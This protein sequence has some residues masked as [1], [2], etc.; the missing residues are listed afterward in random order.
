MKRHIGLL[1]LAALSVVS[2]NKEGEI[3]YREGEQKTEEAT[4]TRALQNASDPFAIDAMQQA[5]DLV[6]A[7]D[8]SVPRITLQPTGYYV[9]F[10]PQDSVQ[11]ATLDG[12]GIELFSHPLDNG[13]YPE[14]E[15]EE[16]TEDTPI[17]YEPLYAVVPAGFV[18]PEE[19]DYELIHGVFIQNKRGP[20]SDEGQL[21]AGVYASVLDASLRLTGNVSSARSTVQPFQPSARLRF[22]ITD[23]S[24]YGINNDTLPLVGAKVLAF[25]YT[26]VSWGVTDDN[27][28]TGPI[29]TTNTPVRYEVHWGDDRWNVYIANKNKKRISILDGTHTG[30]VDVVFADGTWE[31][32]MSG[33][34]TALYSYFYRDY[35][36]TRYLIKGDYT[37]DI[38]TMTKGGRSSAAPVR[39]LREIYFYGKYKG[40]SRYHTPEKAMNTMFHELGHISHHKLEPLKFIVRALRKDG[41][42][43]A[44]GVEYAYMKSFF[45]EYTDP[46]NRGEKNKYTRVVECLLK[47][48][49]SM[50]DIQHGFHESGGWDSW[51]VEMRRIV[52]GRTDMT[53]DEKERLCEI[54]NIIFSHPN[55]AALDLRDIVEAEYESVGLNQLVRLRLN[56]D[57]RALSS[58]PNPF[59]SIEGW[60]IA[61]SDGVSVPHQYT[62]NS[63]FVY[64][65]RPWRKKIRLTANVFGGERVYE[66]ELNV[67]SQ[68]IVER[69]ADP[70][71][72]REEVFKLRQTLTDA[73]VEVKKWASGDNKTELLSFPSNVPNGRFRFTEKGERTVKVTVYYPTLRGTVEYEIK[74]LVRDPESDEIFYILNPPELFAYDTTYRAMY[75]VVGEKITGIER[76]ECD[77]CHYLFYLY[78][79]DSWSF[80][81]NSGV[82]S[83]SIPKHGT[84][85]DYCL[86]IFYTVESS[87]DVREAR[88]F[89]S[90]Y[91]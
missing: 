52:T 85:L 54:V 70:I 32:V 89:V 48:G 73:G 13:I 76:I 36:L 46:N 11:M 84:Y 18:F 44:T 67:G 12:L 61:D 41:E 66:K 68:D 37:L 82:L 51:Q 90:N 80:D 15:P 10:N 35:P 31:G 59:I 5:L 23:K 24:G 64:F 74:T 21:P 3:F 57:A 8:P 63:L 34:H 86:T 42:S 88:L 81:R 6:A 30:P 78:F 25:Y 56:E 1:L 87:D 43:W 72:G 65:T 49:F 9:K 7:D 71:V 45:P 60:E 14:T 38:A 20:A 17:V 39:P 91:R 55:D 50:G 53:D 2:C 69:P 40:A 22:E 79:D 28:E 27:G 4:V 58:G 19:V 29:C 83:F 75:G 77:H 16:V 26:D 47:N 62:D 33:M